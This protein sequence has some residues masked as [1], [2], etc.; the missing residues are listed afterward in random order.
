MKFN[1]CERE[2][3]S[4]G[5]PGSDLAWL[6][7]CVS[8]APTIKT[9]EPLKLPPFSAKRFLACF[10]MAVTAGYG[11]CQLGTMFRFLEKRQFCQ[12]FSIILKLSS[13]LRPSRFLPI[14]TTFPST[15]AFGGS[16]ELPM[17]G[18]SM[19]SNTSRTA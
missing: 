12:E 18:S 3:A 16:V 11:A 5:S 1:G 19:I 15:G 10:N 14:K 6:T 13:N 9:S 4:V 8:S 2:Q 17:A 7:N